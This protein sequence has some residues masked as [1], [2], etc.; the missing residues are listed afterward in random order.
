MHDENS[1]LIARRKSEKGSEAWIIK[2][3]VFFTTDTHIASETVRH[4]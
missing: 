2:T 4:Q 3:A 1:E